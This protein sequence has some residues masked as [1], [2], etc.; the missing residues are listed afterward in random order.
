MIVAPFMACVI[1]SSWSKP[2]P[3][4]AHF[5]VEA[6][7]QLTQASVMDVICANVSQGQKSVPLKGKN[8][9]TLRN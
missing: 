8:V 3:S 7:G 6:A 1:A 4:I 9:N 5:I 2:R